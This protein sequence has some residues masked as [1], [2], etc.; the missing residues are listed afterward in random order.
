MSYVHYTKIVGLL[1]ISPKDWAGNAF[2]QARRS[3]SVLSEH[4]SAARL[5][6][7]RAAKLKAALI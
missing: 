1:A 2:A 5:A 7:L 3:L 6:S 4:R